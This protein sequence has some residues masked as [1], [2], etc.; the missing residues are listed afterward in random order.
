MIPGIPP[1]AEVIEVKRLTGKLTFKNPP[2]KFTEK[3][4]QAPCRNDI[5]NV[6]KK[7]LDLYI[8]NRIIATEKENTA[9]TIKT[10]LPS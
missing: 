5:K 4:A 7:C 8:E 2:K 1:I 6:L 9:Y 10:S 3:R